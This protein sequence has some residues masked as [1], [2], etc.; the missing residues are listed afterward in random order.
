MAK[1][2]DSYS[3]LTST[4]SCREWLLQNTLYNWKFWVIL[5]CVAVSA[6][7]FGV[8][9]GAFGIACT[10]SPVL[11]KALAGAVLLVAICL[12]NSS[13]VARALSFVSGIFSAFGSNNPG[14][15]SDVGDVDARVE[16]TDTSAISNYASFITVSV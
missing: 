12:Y 10:V 7:G 14:T 15:G 4:P 11:V 2:Q 3:F 1:D 6:T 8:G 5:A 9:F 16:S 13:T